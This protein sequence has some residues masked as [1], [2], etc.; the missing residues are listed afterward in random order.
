MQHWR[1]RTKLVCRRG[2][3]D[4]DFHAAAALLCKDNTGFIKLTEETTLGYT[5]ANLLTAE[6]CPIESIG[7]SGRDG[8]NT[9]IAHGKNEHI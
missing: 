3:G 4:K 5:P 8:Y 2:P 9:L 1:R 7:F 6:I